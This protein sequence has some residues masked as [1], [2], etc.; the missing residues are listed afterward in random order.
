MTATI[1]FSL[2]LLLLSSSSVSCYRLPP[3][4][5]NNNNN[6]K[7]SQQQ[8]SLLT[9]K[10]KETKQEQ[11]YFGQ[12][13][14]Q[15]LKNNDDNDISS[16]S[17]NGEVSRR[18]LILGG[19]C[20]CALCTTF[21]TPAVHGDDEIWMLQKAEERIE[22]EKTLEARFARVMAG[23]MADYEAWEEVRNF[24]TNLFSS[25][26]K[27]D[28]VLEIGV[29]SGPNLPY[30]GSRA[31]QVLAVEPNRM[32]DDYMYAA[33]VRTN[34][35]LTIVPGK[36][37][38]IPVPDNSVDVVVGTMV[39]CS[40]TS[41]KQS[42]QEVYRVL[43]PGGKYLFTEHT[44]APDD[45]Q[46]LGLAQTIT[47]PLQLKL[48]EGCHLRRNPQLFVEETF[49]K[50][51]VDAKRFVLSNTGKTPPNWPPHFLLAPHYVGTATKVV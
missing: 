19:A 21:Y 12:Q 17:G 50:S 10:Q 37:E 41:V 45:W 24:K 35:P 32:F 49:Q 29:G 13:L 3:L 39:L 36:A 5:N 27:G 6:G 7:Q 11:R 47:E 16:S 14:S 46:L 51:N 43:K 26:K 30:Y 28:T 25:V 2:L 38:E 42:L 15:Q 40:V 1:L 8:Q 34:T 23:G 31:S 18:S 20:T 44:K 33:A 9:K 48:A 22:K 4:N